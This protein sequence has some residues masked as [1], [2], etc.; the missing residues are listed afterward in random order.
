MAIDLVIKPH[1]PL[2]IARHKTDNNLFESEAFIPGNVLAGALARLQGDADLIRQVLLNLVG[3][4]LKFTPAGGRVTLSVREDA[5]TVRLAVADTG[6]G[7]AAEEMRAIFQSFYRTRSAAQVE[8]VGLGLSIVKEIVSLHGGHLDVHSRSGLGSTFGVHLPKEMHHTTSET[9]LTVASCDPALQ[10]HLAAL[11]LQLVAELATARGVAVILPAEQ[12]ATL[13][14]AAAMGLGHEAAGTLL[15]AGSELARM[16]STE[17]ILVPDAGMLPPSLEGI[18]DLPGTAMMAPLRL[19]T[20]GD[21]D[22]DRGLI[23]AARRLG[24]GGFGADDLVLLG[25]LAEILSGAWGAALAT[26]DERSDQDLVTEALTALT[27]LRRRG[28]P[29]ADPLALRLLSRT[30]RR[31]GLSSFEVRLLQYAG[32]LHDAGMV[33]LEPDLLL[34]PAA[35]DLDERDLIGRHPQRG[36]DLLGP[37]VELPELQNIIRHHHEWYDGRG[38]PEGRCGE[39]IPLGSRILAVVDAFFA[40]IRSRPWREGLPVAA[41]VTEIQRHAGSQFDARVVEGFLSTLLEEGLLSVTGV[42]PSVGGSRR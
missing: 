3:N 34:K 38:Y 30:G 23:L 11:T 37:L 26:R 1:G 27:G 33:L 10:N 21:Q 18:V 6:P 7:I 14:V 29:T 36:I 39:A 32:A 31:L 20:G 13:V 9:E 35:L 22:A 19:G 17:A 25:I 12:P 16:A 40:M 41:A 2:C 15:P 8:G 24:G 42:E 5:S 4:A 28:V